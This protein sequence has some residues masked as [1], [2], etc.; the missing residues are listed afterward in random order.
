MIQF[1]LLP[2]VKIEYIKTRYRKRVIMFVSLVASAVCLLIFLILFLYVRVNQPRDIRNITADIQMNLGKI[3]ETE[4][5][6]KIITIQSQLG[7]LTELH[8]KKIVSSR[9]LEYFYQL[10][11]NAATISETNIDFE[12]NTIVVKGGADALST[13]NKFADTL[14]FTDYKVNNEN[15]ATGKAFKDVVLQ[16]FSAAKSGPSASTATYTLVFSFDPLIFSQVNDKAE[17]APTP[18]SLT[19]PQII[20]TRSVVEKPN[21]LFEAS[22]DTQTTDGTG[23]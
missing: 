14:K 12:G 13:V 1:N 19:I 23:Q 7:S 15:A 21:A 8:D 11:P 22:A 20:S 10:T 2:D 16:D 6:D 9:L 4:D 17:S 3:R 18:V 5:L